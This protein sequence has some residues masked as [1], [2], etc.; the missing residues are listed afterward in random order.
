MFNRANLKKTLIRVV[1][2]A[3]TIVFWQLWWNRDHNERSNLH[4]LNRTGVFVC[5]RNEENNY[6]T[7]WAKTQRNK[8]L[9]LKV[10]VWNGNKA[11]Q[12]DQHKFH[13]NLK[14]QKQPQ[15]LKYIGH[16]RE[17]HLNSKGNVECILHCTGPWKSLSGGTNRRKLNRL[18]GLQFEVL[19]FRPLSKEAKWKYV[20][21][22]SY[23]WLQR[24]VVEHTTV[25]SSASVERQF[26]AAYAT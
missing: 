11:V 9:S 8:N 26:N 3:N 13:G 24:S 17:A 6:T 16:Q 25:R 20:W 14:V 1:D 4:K 18:W 2:K 10:Q 23:G 21:W 5:C 15:K 19:P 22:W 12:L 7:L